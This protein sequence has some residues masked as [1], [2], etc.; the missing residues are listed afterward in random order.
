VRQVRQC[1]S[2]TFALGLTNST[3]VGLIS[4]ELVAAVLKEKS[5]NFMLCTVHYLGRNEEVLEDLCDSVKSNISATG[6]RVCKSG[7]DKFMS[8]GPQPVFRNHFSWEHQ[9]WQYLKEIPSGLFN[10]TISQAIVK[11]M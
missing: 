5:R 8:S 1:F 10:K 7:L 11:E 9:A 6:L 4:G 2:P 3:I